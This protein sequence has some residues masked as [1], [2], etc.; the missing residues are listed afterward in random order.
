MRITF[1]LPYASWTGGIRVIAIYAQELQRRGHE[2]LLVSQPRRQLTNWQRTKSLLRGRGWPAR[3]A[4]E[5][6]Y[7]ERL[8]VPHRTLDVCRPVTDR[9]VPDADVVVATWWETAPWVAALSER[10]GAKAY[11]IQDY[12]ANG[13]QPLHKVVPTWRLPLHHISISNWLIDLVH[14]HVG[15][16]P[17]AYVPNS[18]DV[19]QFD[20]PPRGRRE[21][22]TVGLMFSSRPQKGADLAIE[23]I[24]FARTVEP[25]LRVEAFGADPAGSGLTLPAG[26][27]FVA[28]AP[29]E[30]LPSIYAA[31]DAW[32]FSSRLEGFGLPILEAMACRTPVIATPAGAA[33]DLVTNDTGMLLT[34]FEPEDMAGAIIAFA[35]MPE[36]RWRA[37]SEAAWHTARSYSWSDATDRFEAA[38]ADAAGVDVMP[39]VRA[40]VGS[41]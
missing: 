34:S 22:P 38:L 6:D 26:T 12:G 24:E 3:P 2:V 37:M 35:R 39:R 27:N 36:A 21:R 32:L 4:P 1:V 28:R 29:E 17:I 8:G 14:R 40:E 41:R 19:V 16:V 9:D 7:L 11:F 18:V 25:G 5:L 15:E 13:G 23:A 31:C 20:A 33:P 30:Q 10:C